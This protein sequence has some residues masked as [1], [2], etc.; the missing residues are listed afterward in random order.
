MVR[1]NHGMILS[2]PRSFDNSFIPFH[3]LAED[4]DESELMKELEDLEQEELNS[5]LLGIHVNEDK[6][7]DVPVGDLKV[8]IVANTN[9]KCK[10]FIVRHI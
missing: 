4:F 9:R 1:F 8:P 5:E 10:R 7:P 3:R 6:L 2:F